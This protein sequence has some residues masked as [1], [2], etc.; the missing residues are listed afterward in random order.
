MTNW[1]S[2]K[3]QLQQFLASWVQLMLFAGNKRSNYLVWSAPS[4]KAVI[5]ETR[6]EVPVQ[7]KARCATI[8]GLIIVPSKYMV[9][10]V[11]GNKSAVQYNL[12][13]VHFKD[14]HPGSRSSIPDL[15]SRG[16]KGTRS[17]ADPGSHIWIRNTGDFGLAQAVGGNIGYG[18]STGAAVL[19]THIIGH[20]SEAFMCKK[21]S[22]YILF[23]QSL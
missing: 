17:L 4:T 10:G 2:Q 11:L 21:N 5:W 3:L 23:R 20:L 16:Q 22:P 8:L 19:T 9:R 15:R 7:A 18:L 12:K 13:T 6:R 14:T 1:P